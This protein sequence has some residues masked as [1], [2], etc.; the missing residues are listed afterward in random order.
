M[1]QLDFTAFS[2]QIIWLVITFVILYALMAKVALP[3]IGSVLE[4]RQAKINDNLDTAEN[5]RTEAK[6]DAET[7]ESALAEAREQARQTVMHAYQ[8]ANA[9]S[10]EQ[11][12][13]LGERLAVDIKKAETRIGEAKDAVVGEVRN[14]AESIAADIVDRLVNITPNEG[15][16]VQAVDAAMKEKG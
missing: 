5:L 16:V 13:E 7:Y 6:A 10:T 4:D 12:E 3:R 1:P 11:H 14:I 8:E 2:P 15:T 9:F